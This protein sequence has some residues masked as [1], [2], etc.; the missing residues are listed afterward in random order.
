MLTSSSNTSP[1]TLAPAANSC[2]GFRQRSMVLLPHPD[3]PMIAVTVWAGTSSD[4]SRTA[5]C[6]PNIAVRWDASSRSRVLADATIALAGHPAGG[7]GDDEH[8]PHKHE[9]GGPGQAMPL[10]EGA[11]RVHVD[12]QRQRLHRLGHRQC[13]VQVAQRGEEERRGL[14][15]DA[16]DAD[17]TSRHDPAERGARDDLERRPPAGVAE[18]K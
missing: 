8:E 1:W 13:E 5:R 10:L 15:R 16:R 4:T 2:M 9:R 11:G 14:T 17:E 7:E 3:G 18:P 12:L 6:C